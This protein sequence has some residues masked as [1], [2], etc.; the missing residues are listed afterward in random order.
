M[1]GRHFDNLTSE[2]LRELQAILEE[3]AKKCGEMADLLGDATIRTDGYVTVKKGVFALRNLLGKQLGVL[4]V[5]KHPVVST[6][7]FR[8]PKK[9]TLRKVAEAEGVY[10]VSQ[11]NPTKKQAL[12]RVKK[13]QKDEE[14]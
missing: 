13:I 2:N 1:P 10:D 6:W 11:G 12:K 7:I 14:G 5:S 9:N 3:Y 8:K 4:A